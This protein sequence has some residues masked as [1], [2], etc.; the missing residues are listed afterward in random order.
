MLFHQSCSTYFQ[1]LGT[2]IFEIFLKMNFEHLDLYIS[3][4]KVL[5]FC[6]VRISLLP[7]IAF[8]MQLFVFVLFH[9]YEKVK[10][11]IKYMRF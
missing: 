5:K 1:N 4:R 11:S 3:N 2:K 9:A 7:L 10:L 8:F 6:K